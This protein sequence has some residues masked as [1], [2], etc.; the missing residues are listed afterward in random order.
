LKNDFSDAECLRTV[1]SS[2]YINRNTCQDGKHWVKPHTRKI[3]GRD[4]KIY[5]KKI[6]GYCCSNYSRYIEMAKQENIE[7]DNLFM[8]LT[9][10]GESRMEPIESR[11]IIA[12]IIRN[13]RT[14]STKKLN[15]REVVHK[16][17]QFSCWRKS[18]PNYKRL[19]NPGKHDPIDMRS[20]Q[21][22]KIIA[23]EVIND[24]EKNNPIPG[25]CHYFSGPPDI[26]K[27]PWQK[28]Y[29]DLPNIPNFH[30]VRLKK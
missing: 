4:G 20:W 9:V 13:R 30:F 6:S 11:K 18:D 1:D 5:L 3:K 19:Q 27:H 12:W 26:K 29:F 25:I 8:A 21:E 23:E 15:Y 17:N 7:L 2:N 10:Y 28:N 14:Q 22:C 16:V 24:A